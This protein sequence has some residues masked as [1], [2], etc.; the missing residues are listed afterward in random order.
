M[1]TSDNDGCRDGS[2]SLQSRSGCAKSFTLPIK[3]QAETITGRQRV[4]SMRC[5]SMTRGNVRHQQRRSLR[6]AAA[7]QRCPVPGRR[8]SLFSAKA[9]ESGLPRHGQRRRASS[10]VLKQFSHCVNGQAALRQST[11]RR[12]TACRQPIH[13]LSVVHSIRLAVKPE[14]AVSTCICGTTGPQLVFTCC[15]VDVRSGM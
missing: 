1:D 9:S 13:P 6:D 8:A 11:C 7:K 10:I 15:R 14:I 4:A 12:D 3:T 2:D 5:V